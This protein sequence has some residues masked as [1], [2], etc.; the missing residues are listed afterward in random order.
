MA[1]AVCEL[2][3]VLGQ[4]PEGLQ[5]SHT[6]QL[7][8]TTPA[9]QQSQ[10][11]RRSW[12]PRAQAGAAGGGAGRPSRR[13]GAA[14]NRADAGAAGGWGAAYGHTNVC[15]LQSLLRS[16][17]RRLQLLQRWLRR[18]AGRRL[19]WMM[20]WV[21][22]PPGAPCVVSGR[23]RAPTGKVHTRSQL[24]QSLKFRQV[25]P[26]GPLQSLPTPQSLLISTATTRTG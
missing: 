14:E 11:T 4:P 23:S 22:V 15:A 17:R 26:T 10:T 13:A 9:R 5:H 16:C 24:T 8:Q 2:L 20:S 6:H 12:R 1:S 3:V 21:A 18:D 19:R 25:A 7:Q